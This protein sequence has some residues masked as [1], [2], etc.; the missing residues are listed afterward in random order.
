MRAT[1]VESAWVQPSKTASPEC[2][3]AIDHADTEIGREADEA[4]LAALDVAEAACA[5]GSGIA[6]R[7]GFIAARRQRWD[8][9][10]LAFVDELEGPRPV[11]SAGAQLLAVLPLA[12]PRVR[13]RAARLGGGVRRPLG[14]G[15]EGVSVDR[16]AMLRCGG[17][18]II[19]GKIACN[20]DPPR[21][22]QHFTCRGGGRRKIVS[23]SEELW[24]VE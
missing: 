9:A 1:D 4:A 13:R 18:P 14:P 5:A 19:L 16:L 17:R 12:S 21:C 2:R 23:A 15:F 3:A 22:T 7:R 10:A 11:P 20:R 6:W 24:F 8:E